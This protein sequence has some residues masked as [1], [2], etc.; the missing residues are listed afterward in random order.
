MF[1]DNL[2]QLR[3]IR[4][5]TQEDVAKAMQVSKFTVMNWENGKVQMKPAQFK[6]FCYVVGA[7]ED[8]I[9]LPEV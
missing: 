3:K 5:L 9:S 6:M 7:P 2:V 1:K 8:C 4:S